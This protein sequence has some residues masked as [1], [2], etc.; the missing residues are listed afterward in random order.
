LKT[1]PL[2]ELDVRASNLYA[3]GQNSQTLKRGG[4]DYLEQIIRV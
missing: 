2:I 4:R 3:L 1:N